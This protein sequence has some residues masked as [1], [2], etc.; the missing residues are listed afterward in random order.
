MMNKHV[1]PI[2]NLLNLEPCKKKIEFFN[3]LLCVIG[4]CEN[5]ENSS[6]FINTK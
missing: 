2:Q 1:C 3:N 6:S 5:S 4:I